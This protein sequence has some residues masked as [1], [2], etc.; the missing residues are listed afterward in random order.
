MPIGE[1]DIIDINVNVLSGTRVVLNQQI[2]K[3]ILITN[4]KTRS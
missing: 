2:K 1:I 3:L 4:S